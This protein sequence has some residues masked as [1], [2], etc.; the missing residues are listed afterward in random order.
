MSEEMVKDFTF[1]QFKELFPEEEDLEKN[2]EIVKSWIDN[3]EDKKIALWDYRCLAYNEI[4]DINELEIDN[5][6]VNLYNESYYIL[7]DDEADELFDKMV[8][9]LIEEELYNIP[10][11]LKRYFNE[12]DYKDDIKRWDGR[13]SILAFCDHY[14]NE[15]H[16]IT[17]NKFTYNFCES[18]YIYRTN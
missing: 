12:Q 10:E 2:Y 9:N 11:H 1:E 7:T 4:E 8:D 13:E 16:V 5:D 3:G 6:T 18:I 14:E 15:I 17:L